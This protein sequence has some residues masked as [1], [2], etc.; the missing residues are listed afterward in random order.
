M[1][2]GQITT[3]AQHAFKINLFSFSLTEKKEEN[4]QQNI[5]NYLNVS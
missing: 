2:W 1:H 4:P 5:V 3:A